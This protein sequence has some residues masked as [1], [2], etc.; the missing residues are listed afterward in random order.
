MNKEIVLSG[1]VDERIAL[2]PETKGWFFG[3]FMQKYPEF[4][5]D[6]VEI[7]WSRLKKGDDREGLHSKIPTKTFV[8]LLDGIFTISF[9]D[10]QKEI[11][12]S[13]LGDF[14]LF[15]ASLTSHVSKPIT[16]AL[17][18]SVRTPSKR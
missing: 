11:T 14:V 17:L 8:I 9:P 6:D 16:D 4:C 10:L 1:N 12:L 3:S 5:S 18:I 7:K 13:K 15:D 2:H